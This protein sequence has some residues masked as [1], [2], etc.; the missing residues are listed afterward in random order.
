MS[1]ERLR[2][3]LTSAGPMLMAASRLADPL[4]PDAIRLAAITTK[5]KKTV[6]DHRRIADIEFVGKLWTHKGRVCIPPDALEKACEETA[7]ARAYCRRRC[8]LPDGDGTSFEARRLRGR[9][10]CFGP[11]FVGSLASRKC[12]EL[13]PPRRADTG[14]WSGPELQE[15]LSELGSTLPIIFLTGYPDIPSHGAGHQGR[16]G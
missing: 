13:H 8:V 6:S 11:A 3:K 14:T 4:D 10:L 9:D 1:I 15:R 5:R 12:A 16:C 7:G 2:L